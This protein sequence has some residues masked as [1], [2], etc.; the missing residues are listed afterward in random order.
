MSLRPL[1]LGAR[2]SVE[3][4]PIS[5][6][7]KVLSIHVG[8]LGHLIHREPFDLGNDLSNEPHKGGFIPFPPMGD[9]G[10]VWGVRFHEDPIHGTRADAL[11]YL[12][13]I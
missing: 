3:V 4:V 1:R 2:N 8:G 7:K 9:R 13:Q 12:D 6:S 11:R 10:K 5:N